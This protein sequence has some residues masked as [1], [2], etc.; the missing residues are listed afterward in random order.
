[1]T[2]AKSAKGSLARSEVKRLVDLDRKEIDDGATSVEEIH[3]AIA[4]CRSTSSS[5]SISL[6]KPKRPLRQGTR[7]M[8]RTSWVKNNIIAVVGGRA[9]DPGVRSV[10]DGLRVIAKD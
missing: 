10:Q 9:L 4:N 6:R 8:Q 3:K 7:I 1:M 2:Q 5:D